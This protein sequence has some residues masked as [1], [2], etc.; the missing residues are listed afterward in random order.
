[1]ISR[2]FFI[3]PP[4]LAQ[5]FL[6]PSM[7]LFVNRLRFIRDIYYTRRACCCCH[8]FVYRD[9]FTSGL[10]RAM[11]MWVSRWTSCRIIVYYIRLICVLYIC[12]YVRLSI[13]IKVYSFALS[14]SWKFHRACAYADIVVF[15][16][17]S[18][19]HT[20]DIV[21]GERTKKKNIPI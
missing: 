3:N 7:S 8:I 19:L 9:I 14:L 12:M 5:L 6:I 2:F 21:T 17:K 13:Y 11:F 1:M 16:S 20:H 18:S 15:N 10:H 4:S